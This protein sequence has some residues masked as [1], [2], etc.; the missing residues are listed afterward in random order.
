M[1]AGGAIAGGIIVGGAFAYAGAQEQAD[2][3][4]DA[5]RTQAQAAVRSAQIAAN[6]TRQG[7]AMQADAM[8]DQARMQRDVAEAQM[9]QTERFAVREELR[10]VTGQ[11][12]K[13]TF[14]RVASAF[15]SWAQGN[16]IAEER[17]ALEQFGL[18][19]EVGL[20]PPPQD[21]SLW[22]MMTTDLLT[23]DTTVNDNPYRLE[24][25]MGSEFDD[26][27]NRLYPGGDSGEPPS[28][29]DGPIDM[30]DDMPEGSDAGEIL[31]EAND[32]VDE[33]D[34]ETEDPDA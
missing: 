14:D 4:K 25:D 27:V 26:E 13:D 7:A 2:A 11:A 30:P 8:R 15:V 29:V 17:R 6:A 34:S 16:D 32:L 28:P 1:P 9:E 12:A 18:Q 10:V 23:G 31:N 22:D 33:A 3:A 19:D 20:Q 24:N 5:A 21:P